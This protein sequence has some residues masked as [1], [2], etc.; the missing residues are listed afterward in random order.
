MTRHDIFHFLHRSG[1]V[2]EKCQSVHSSTL[3]RA[4]LE[5]DWLLV[6]RHQFV[7]QLIK[8]PYVTL[9]HDDVVIRKSS[10]WTVI[11]RGSCLMIWSS[12][13]ASNNRNKDA[14]SAE[15]KVLL[16][17]AVAPSG[18]FT[19]CKVKWHISPD[20]CSPT[21]EMNWYSYQITGV[22]LTQ[23]AGSSIHVSGLGCCYI[24]LFEWITRQYSSISVICY[25][26]LTKLGKWCLS[27]AW[28]CHI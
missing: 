25:I 14:N 15:N 2:L 27:W 19:G 10:N 18:L 22:I 26:P 6:I 7:E 16:T 11:V 12:L 23:T 4:G 28:C 3:H 24:L 5:T 17:P 21:I 20:E 9:S 13:S 1:H 8:A